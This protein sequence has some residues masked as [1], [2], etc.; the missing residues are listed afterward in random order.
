MRPD[1]F[2]IGLNDGTA[3][4]QTVSHAHIHVIPRWN[5]D[6]PDP[7]GGVRWV[8]PG[9][10]PIGGS[11]DATDR[12]RTDRFMVNL[13]RLLDEGLFMASYKFA[14]LLALADL[15][16]EQGDD[17][18]APWESATDDIAEKFIQYYWRQVAPYPTAGEAQSSSRIPAGRRPSSIWYGGACSIRRLAP[19]RMRDRVA[20]AG[21]KVARVVREMPLW[22]LQRIGKEQLNFLYENTGDGGVIQFLPGI[23]Y[24]FRKFH[25]LIADLVQGAWVRYVRQQNLDSSV[26]PPT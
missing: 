7:R 9:K 21:R 19:S 8:I 11:R 20:P 15:S 25:A 17:S 12:R 3:A 5:G 18:G 13:Q 26:R 4:G 24:C 1:A 14:L 6:V 22:R 16:I 2:T 10:A 23:A